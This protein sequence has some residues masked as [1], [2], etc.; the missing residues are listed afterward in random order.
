M[1]EEITDRVFDVQKATMVFDQDWLDGSQSS[2]STL[3][4]LDQM[5]TIS[6]ASLRVYNQRWVDTFF[7]ESLTICDLSK[8]VTFSFFG[9]SVDEQAPACFSKSSKNRSRLYR[10][11][12]N[13]AW[14]LSV[15]VH[16]N[17]RKTLMVSD[18][19]S[20]VFVRHFPIWPQI[21]RIVRF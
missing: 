4:K 3:L 11:F 16:Q 10:L 20:R 15:H 19:S 14:W 13:M 2:K 21:F 12:R 7:T 17:V 18:N 6:G 5:R 9:A 8:Q 1:R